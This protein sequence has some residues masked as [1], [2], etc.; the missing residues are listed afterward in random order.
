VG[1]RRDAQQRLN[2]QVGGGKPNQPSQNL[3]AEREATVT[4]DDLKLIKGIGAVF[5]ERLRAGGICTFLDMANS[6]PEQ[7]A[8]THQC[9]RMA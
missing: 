7:L 4:Q 3:S 2:V 6:T 5:A 8:I 9:R 1:A